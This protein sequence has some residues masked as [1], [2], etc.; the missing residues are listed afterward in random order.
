[1]VISP[2]SLLLT[3][4]APELPP[5]DPDPPREI[6]PKLL[7]PIPPPPPMLWAMTPRDEP[8]VVV[9]TPLLTMETE[10]PLPPLSEFPF[11]ETRRLAEVPDEPPVPPML[12]PTIPWAEVPLVLTTPLAALVMDT[13]PP[14]P[15]NFPAPL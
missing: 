4:T 12:W 2:V 1:V 8:P 11:N 13:G 15:P 3:D 9:T 6:R 7:P 10:P 5:L 14:F